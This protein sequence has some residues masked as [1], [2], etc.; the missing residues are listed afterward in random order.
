MGKRKLSSM[1]PF[2]VGQMSCVSGGSCTAPVALPTKVVDGHEC[3]LL[4]AFSEKGWLPNILSGHKRGMACDVVRYVQDKMFQLLEDVEENAARA[5]SSEDLSDVSRDASQSEKKLGR[6]SLGLSDD[7]DEDCVV[8]PSK[9]Q[10]GLSCSKVAPSWTTVLFEDV[11]FTVRKI[12]KGKGFFIRVEDDLVQLLHLMQRKLENGFVVPP[13]RRE[14]RIS[15][16]ERKAQDTARVRWIFH[17][18]AWEVYY[19]DE[20]GKKHRTVKGLTVPRADVDGNMLSTKAYGEMRARILDKA[21]KLWN[22]MDKSDA[23]R[24]VVG[25]S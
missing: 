20:D 24:I 16:P 5:A 8:T 15:T 18:D 10:S 25:E 19:T 4:S 17:L 6:E 23:S 1:R 11:E 14:L 21:R 12:G 3:V 9:R 2:T 13:P 22:A 7:S